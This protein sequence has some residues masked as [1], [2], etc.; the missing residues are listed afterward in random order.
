MPHT[1]TSSAGL[2]GSVLMPARMPQARRGV[3]GSGALIRSLVPKLPA[4]RP[5]RGFWSAAVP[6]SPS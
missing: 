4:S 6:P 2:A 1:T 3:N 5:P